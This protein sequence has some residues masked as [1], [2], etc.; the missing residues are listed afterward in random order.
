MRIALWLVAAPLLVAVAAADEAPAVPD[1]AAAPELQV[2]SLGVPVHTMRLYQTRTVAHP[3]GSGHDLLLFYHDFQAGLPCQAVALDMVTGK[4][5]RFQPAASGA[6]W[7]FATGRDGREYMGH[8]GS[9][10]IWV[11]DA[12]TKEMSFIESGIPD[13]GTVSA[14]TC[15][16]DGMIY[17]STTPKIKTFRYD[18]TTGQ[19][20]DYGIQGPPRDYLGYGYT[21]AADDTHVYTAAGKIPWYIVACDTETGQQQCI[22]EGTEADYIEVKQ[23][24]YGCVG[25]HLIGYNTPNQERVEYWLYHGRALRRQPGEAPPWPVPEQETPPPPRLPHMVLD[26]ADPGPD[27]RAEVWWL[28]P[29]VTPPAEVPAG[30]TAEQL[31]WKVARFE[32]TVTPSEIRRLREMPDGRLI[33]SAASYQNFFIHDPA[34]GQTTTLGKIPLSHYATAFAGGKVY[35]VGYP[36][37]PVYEYDPQQPWTPGRGTPLAP[38]PAIDQPGSNPRRL[39]YLNQHIKTHHGYTAVTGADGRIYV[40]AHAERACVGGGLGWWDPASQTSGGIRQP[41]FELHDVAG[42]IAVRAGR[43]I[44][45]G[46]RTVRDPAT[47]QTAPEAK[48]FVYDTE[49]GTIVRDF[50]PLPGRQSTGPIEAVGETLVMGLAPKAGEQ[51]ATVFVADVAAGQVLRQRDL[52]GERRGAFR[53]GPDG[54]VWTFLDDVLV[55]IAPESLEVTVVGRLPEPGDFAFA[56]RDIYFAGTPQLRC[57]RGLLP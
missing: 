21:V 32:V 33:G 44:V 29:E 55:R 18:P 51:P 1:L 22:V 24:R 14:I 28:P 57:A 26:G 11:Y 50:A 31:G 45:Y 13:V 48:L 8:Y 41:W 12:T 53:A 30:A 38:A 23:E 25:V 47:G 3:D 39:V 5:Y 46:S 19:F 54:S 2:Q 35:L 10:A 40:G 42:L 15:G 6:P 16:T 27:G 56:G 4:V 9:A 37:T 52:P 34:T 7:R 20:R 43:W 36:S 17:C 49:A